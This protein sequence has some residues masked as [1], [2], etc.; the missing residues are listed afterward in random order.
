MSDLRNDWRSYHTRHNYRAS[1]LCGSSGEYEGKIPTWSLFHT[2][3]TCRVTLPCGLT[4]ELADVMSDWSPCHTQHMCRVSLQCKL[5]MSLKMWTA[6]KALT[7]RLSFVWLLSCVDLLMNLHMW[8]LTE[9]LTTHTAH[10]QGYC[11]V[12]TQWNSFR[13]ELWQ[14]P[15]HMSHLFMALLECGL[16]DELENKI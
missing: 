12:W 14:K 5:A 2:Q 8:C 10:E 6:I 13:H 16:S 15:L 11:P 3:H 1:V 9:A 7:T 4:E